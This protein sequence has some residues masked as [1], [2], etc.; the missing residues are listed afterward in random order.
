MGLALDIV[1]SVLVFLSTAVIDAVQ[2]LGLRAYER[3][4]ANAVTLWSVIEYAVSCFCFFAFIGYSWWLIL[5]ELL[6]L[7]A[8]SQWSMRKIAREHPPKARV[9]SDD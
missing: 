4:D 6:G 3:R 2:T 1:L 7:I 5:P 8:G 9:L